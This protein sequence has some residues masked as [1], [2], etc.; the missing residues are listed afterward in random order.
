MRAIVV[1]RANESASH[2]IVWMRRCTATAII[3]SVAAVSAVALLSVS[4]MAKRAVASQTSGKATSP[5]TS[6]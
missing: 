4:R 5:V 1:G 3:P 2:A 6:A